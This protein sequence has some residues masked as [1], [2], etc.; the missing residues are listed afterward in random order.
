LT[1]Q[2][3]FYFYGFHLAGRKGLDA[4]RSS[5]LAARNKV[6]GGYHKT[7]ATKRKADKR[8]PKFSHTKDNFVWELQNNLAHTLL[9]L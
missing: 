8:V 6:D 1:A 4:T 3:K 2:E 7:L 5:S 9:N